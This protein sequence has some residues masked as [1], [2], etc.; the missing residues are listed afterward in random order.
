MRGP[1][2]QTTSVNWVWSLGALT[3]IR[4]PATANIPRLA[5]AAKRGICLGRLEEAISSTSRAVCGNPFCPGDCFPWIAGRCCAECFLQGQ[6]ALSSAW[7]AP[8]KHRPHFHEPF[9]RSAAFRSHLPCA[10]P[11]VDAGPLGK[12]G[13]SRRPWGSQVQVVWWGRCCD[14]D[15][16]SGAGQPGPGGSRPQEDLLVG[17]RILE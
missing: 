2:R 17:S 5:V 6:E 8:R 3:L 9:I 11:G 7:G 4:L 13:S 15:A 14:Q 16:C 10:W 1:V 12:V